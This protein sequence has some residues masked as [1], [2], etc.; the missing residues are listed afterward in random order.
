MDLA[1]A[2]TLMVA[3]AA[4]VAI[5][6][7]NVALIIGNTLTHGARYGVATVL[8]TTLGVGCQVVFVVAGLAALLELAA[9]ALHWLRWAGVAYLLWLGI[10]AWRQGGAALAEVV[11]VRRPPWKLFRQ[12]AVMAVLNPKTLLFNAAFLPQFVTAESGAGALGTAAVLYLGVFLCGD[13]LW[14]LAARSARGW[15]L[16]AGRLRHRLTGALYIAAGAGLA[17]ARVDRI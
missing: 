15:L 12:G 9:S 2:L 17:L 6:G 8:G 14:V 1:S 7:P 3:T 11:P 5:P 16:Q 4:L 10:A 13:L